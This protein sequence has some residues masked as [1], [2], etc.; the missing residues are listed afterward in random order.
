MCLPSHVQSKAITH[1]QL[2]P[3]LDPATFVS[4]S[5]AQITDT[6]GAATIGIVEVI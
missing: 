6:V 5:L 2:A 1:N 4:P 3:E